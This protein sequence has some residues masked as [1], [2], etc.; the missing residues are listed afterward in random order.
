MLYLHYAFFKATNQGIAILPVQFDLKFG[1]LGFD[2]FI[3]P[4]FLGL[5]MFQ[6]LV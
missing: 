2:L 1:R 5:A 6:S 3:V 4:C